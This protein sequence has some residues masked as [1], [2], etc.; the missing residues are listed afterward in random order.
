MIEEILHDYYVN[1]DKMS[2]G[3]QRVLKMTTAQCNVSMKTL[4]EK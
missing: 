3:F 1:Y 4:K 2:G